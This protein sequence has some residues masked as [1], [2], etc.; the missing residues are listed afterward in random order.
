M[1]RCANF[2]EEN[3]RLKSIVGQPGADIRVLKDV[4]GKK[5]TARGEAA[6]GGGN[7]DH[8]L[9]FMPNLAT[10]LCAGYIVCRTSRSIS[11]AT[12]SFSGSPDNCPQ[13]AAWWQFQ[14]PA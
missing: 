7:N 1:R 2:E 11:I 13:Q 14:L 5:V 8:C 10:D 4:T 12:P 9:R 6:D 3:R